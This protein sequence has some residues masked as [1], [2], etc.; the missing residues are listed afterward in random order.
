MTNRGARVDLDNVPQQGWWR[1]HYEERPTPCIYYLFTL[2][3]LFTTCGIS[4]EEVGGSG[5]FGLGPVF[6]PFQLHWTIFHLVRALF[7]TP[8]CDTLPP[9][10]PKPPIRTPPP[11][12]NFYPPLPSILIWIPAVQIPYQIAPFI[13][14]LFQCGI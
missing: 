13:Y 7:M 14:L 5:L 10:T 1:G 11:S 4:T 3:L 8:D 2:Y 6:S 9:P 12:Q